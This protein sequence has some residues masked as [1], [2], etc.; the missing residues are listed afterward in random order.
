MIAFNGTNPK[1]SKGTKTA[2]GLWCGRLLVG[3]V[4][5]LIVFPQMYPIAN[6]ISVLY[7]L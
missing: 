2:A 3:V 6:N 1:E 5:L 4:F 7:K